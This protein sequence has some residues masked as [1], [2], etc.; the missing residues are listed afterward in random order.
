MKYEWRIVNLLIFSCDEV[1][2]KR[3][4]DEKEMDGGFVILCGIVFAV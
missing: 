3:D 1:F 4:D 2:D